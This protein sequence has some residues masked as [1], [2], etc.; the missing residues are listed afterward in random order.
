MARTTKSAELR[1][2]RA[3][4]E[5][6][7]KGEVEKDSLTPEQR[8]QI[9]AMI[10]DSDNLKTQ[11]EQIERSDEV[12]KEL[13]A[14]SQKPNH[15]NHSGE[16][17]D[18]AA[19]RKQQVK[20]AFRD[21]L[22]HG[23]AEMKPE[24]R[25][26]LKAEQRTYAP[27]QIAQPAAGYFVPQGFSYEF[28]EALKQT[29]GMLEACRTYPTDSGNPL[30]WPM[31][32]DTANKAVIV[33]EN[34]AFNLVNPTV[35]H[36]TFNAFKYTTGAQATVEQLEDSAFDIESWLK[37]EFVVRFARGVNYDLTNGNGSTAPQGITEAVQTGAT[38][39]T[40]TG[41][42]W[43]NLVDLIHSVDP[44][45]RK[46]KSCKFQFADDTVR[47]IRL[48]K[49]NYGHPIFQTDPTSNLPDRILGFEYVINQDL[50]QINQAG[51][52]PNTGDVVGLFGAM[53]RYVIR[54]VNGLHVQRLNERYAELGLVGFQAYA[55]Y[56]GKLVT[57]SQK[58]ITSLVMS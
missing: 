54:K 35:S 23:N 18:D 32:D 45:Y 20:V 46:D 47:Q 2:K 53:N 48:I 55:R 19:E 50:T 40:D 42:I 5:A 41:L 13:R 24:N 26:I 51:S 31:V 33:G 3:E 16:L 36:L 25:S 14:S 52:P 10:A 56:D 34:T 9:T 12:E 58:A 22:M 15:G 7:I 43:D 37:D 57:A 4:L 27:L 38:S 29:G 49:D 21:F 1:T 44:A 28:D 17:S 39:S 30:L 11:Y 6:K 8:T